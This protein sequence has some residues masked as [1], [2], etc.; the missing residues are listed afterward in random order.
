M[1]LM[2]MPR[3]SAA[4]CGKIVVD[5]APMSVYPA[6]TVAVPSA[7]SRTRALAVNLHWPCVQSAMPQPTSRWPSR[8][9]PL[10]RSHQPNRRAP[11][12]Y[13]S[14]SFFEDRGVLSAGSVS[15]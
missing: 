12:S 13:A 3:V 4:I 8:V 15:T 2:P 14:L 7:R 5:P 10:G 1:A 6:S 11:S 9:P